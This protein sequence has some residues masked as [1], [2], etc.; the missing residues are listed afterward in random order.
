MRPPGFSRVAA[1]KIGIYARNFGGIVLSLPFITD[2]TNFKKI[3]KSLKIG[4][5]KE[6]VLAC[7]GNREFLLFKVLVIDNQIFN[8]VSCR[9]LCV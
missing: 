4:R 6:G 1:W 5:N 8:G 3:Q 9:R 7:L 2:A